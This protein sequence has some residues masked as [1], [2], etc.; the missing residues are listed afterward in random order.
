MKKEKVILATL[1]LLVAL[2]GR[3]QAMEEENQTG[4]VAVR[5]IGPR[6]K[7]VENGA[8]GKIDITLSSSSKTTKSH[9]TESIS[10]T[11]NIMTALPD[12]V[13]DNSH[14]EL[15][16]PSF[17]IS[18]NKYNSNSP[19]PNKTAFSSYLG[20]EAQDNEPVSIPLINDKNR[21]LRTLIFT[22]RMN[23]IAFVFEGNDEFFAH[24]KHSSDVVA[25]YE[26]DF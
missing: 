8:K 18:E 12:L 24:Y 26:G 14:K 1:M 2:E 17:I 22:L 16:C 20:R 10:L 7:N 23:L 5:Y 15:N 13:Y 11:N 21:P 9:Y 3:S 4:R 19:R 6:L 25:L